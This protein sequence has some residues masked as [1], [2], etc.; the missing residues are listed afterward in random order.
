MFVVTNWKHK[1]LFRKFTGK[2]EQ[3]K[4]KQYVAFT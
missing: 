4:G 2:Q 3:K 1:S